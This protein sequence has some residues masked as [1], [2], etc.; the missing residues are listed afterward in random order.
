MA[1]DYS[2]IE[3]VIKILVRPLCPSVTLAINNFFFVCSEAEPFVNKR[4][5]LAGREV[6]AKC[7][8]VLICV[9][10]GK[11]NLAVFRLDYFRLG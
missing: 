8:V 4:N 1:E 6:A 10:L 3:F 2:E 7:R 9:G 5:A 11:L